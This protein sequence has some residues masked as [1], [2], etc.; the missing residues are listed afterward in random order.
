[1][2]VEKTPSKIPVGYENLLEV[3]DRIKENNSKE[4]E[5]IILEVCD[6]TRDRQFEMKIN[7]LKSRE[8][9]QDRQTLA[10]DAKVGVLTRN[11]GLILDGCNTFLQVGSAFFGGG[12]SAIGAGLQGVAQGFHAASS[13]NDKRNNAETTSYD[14]DY[15]RTG[16][17]I[18]EYTQQK[19]KADREHDQATSM[20]DRI[21][22]TIQR[23]FELIA[24]GNA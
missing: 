24:S 5:A 22:Q 12:G 20:I 1:M 11:T 2:A 16:S 3:G 14:H 18:S 8:Q 21:E 6:R 23:T 4:I 17:L 10:V 15:Q 9:Q 7:L 13:N 19:D